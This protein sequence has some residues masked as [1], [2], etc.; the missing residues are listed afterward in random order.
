[1]IDSDGTMVVIQ[2]Q[3]G[4]VEPEVDEEE[5]RAAAAANAEAL[6]EDDEAG[7]LFGATLDDTAPRYKVGPG[8][9]GDAIESDAEDEFDEPPL[10]YDTDDF[11]QDGFAFEDDAS[12]RQK[13]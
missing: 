9:A 12:K 1:M 4:L 10:D 2:L 5:E 3:H 6:D 8:A 13:N 11:E 7:A